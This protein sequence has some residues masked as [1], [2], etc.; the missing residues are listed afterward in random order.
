MKDIERMKSEETRD[1]SVLK[2]THAFCDRE[3]D[4]KETERFRSPDPCGTASGILGFPG[5]VT[6]PLLFLYR[7]SESRSAF[8]RFYWARFDARLQPPATV[9]SRR[10]RC[11]QRAQFIHGN[12][13]D[14]KQNERV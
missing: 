14:T 2:E 7:L 5:T 1:D 13:A 12:G 9:A 3:T 11:V 4:E 10:R 8:C 6:M